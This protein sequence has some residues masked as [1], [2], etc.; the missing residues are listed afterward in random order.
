[1]QNV[2]L[3]LDLG[4]SETRFKLKYNDKE[5]K[6]VITPVHT[7]SNHFYKTEAGYEVP[8][9]YTPDTTTIFNIVGEY[10]GTF[11]N[12]LLVDREFSTSFMKPT[13]NNKKYSFHS[14]LSFS[15]VYLKAARILAQAW[16]VKP[17]ELDINLDL[18]VLMPALDCDEDGIK[19]MEAELRKITTVVD[20]FTVEG[21]TMR[22]DV[23][24][25]NVEIYPEGLAAY[26]YC[27]Y[28]ET[29]EPRQGYEK[30]TEDVVLTLD[31]GA[32]TTDGCVIADGELINNT[33]FT[34]SI[35]GNNV[36]A[37]LKRLIKAKYNYGNIKDEQLE[38]AVK[39][40]YIKDGSQQ[41]DVAE[42]VK[43][44]KVDVAKMLVADIQDTLETFGFSIRSIGSLLAVG[45]GTLGS[46][47]PEIFPLSDSIAGFLKEFSPNL[48]NVQ[49]PVIKDENG[50]P[51]IMSTRLMNINGACLL[52]ES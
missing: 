43:T 2:T 19:A 39:T 29:G 46:D 8:A 18:V 45:G 52:S 25:N 20:V 37:M 1:M 47:R 16:G 21:N 26:V 23:K 40:G 11:A 3:L 4:N 17:E 10:S 35:G 49:L 22:Y 38:E 51:V 34:S 32:G 6:R 24:I 9:I 12:G 48:E 15:L 36:K 5:G 7:E 14:C 13:A 30:Y 41:I 42:L 28:D 27:V 50:Q 31:I 44:A 33:R